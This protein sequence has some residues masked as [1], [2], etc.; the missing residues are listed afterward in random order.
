MASDE[1]EERNSPLSV[2][3][4]NAQPL[5]RRFDI[6]A[7]YFTVV[8]S[9]VGMGILTT[10]GFSLKG[11]E[12]ATAT[13]AL[14]VVGGLLALAG[15]VT[16]SELATT[17]PR[18]GGDYVIVREGFGPALAFVHGW[19]TQIVGFAAPIALAASVAASYLLSPWIIVADGD[20]LPVNV[21]ATSLILAFTVSHCLGWRESS[22]IQAATTVFKIATLA[23]FAALGLTLGNG[24]WSHFSEGRP[25]A[26]Q[27]P[28][29]LAF[30]L[31]YVM[32]GYTGWNGAVYLAGEVKESDRTL[33]RAVLGGCVSVIAL[34]VA[35]NVTYGYALS[36]IMMSGLSDEAVKPVAWLAAD[37]LFGRTT[38]DL[39]AVLIGLG[40]L[41]TLSAFILTGSRVAFAM[42][43]DG[44][45]PAF[46]LK[47]SASRGVPVLA[48]LAQGA[49]SLALLW[50]G[51]FQALL[52]FTGVG[53]T[54]IASFIVAAIFPIRR[55]GLPRGFSV[56]A[57]P[58]PPL[59]FLL[60][61]L[62]MVGLSTIERPVPSL[63]SLAS[64]AAGFPVYYFLVASAKRGRS[65]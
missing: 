24:S 18:V 59:F 38:A 26:Q 3:G 23:G 22:W 20:N 62:A 60:G 15:A 48:T 65:G 8:A 27:Q 10:S 39:F 63:L 2:E 64:V 4:T 42:A 43:L 35:L 21:L 31:V 44:V 36:P 19:S 45:Y 6:G 47:T 41:A 14:W 17:L 7:A 32:Y 50:S 53:L 37:S 46:A 33:P 13:V 30:S 12:S 5:P 55:R 11:T 1:A 58:L 34:Y 25:I 29:V 52:D 16:I 40:L 54:V 57:Y 51:T 56:P 28:G 49:L 9:M 61:T